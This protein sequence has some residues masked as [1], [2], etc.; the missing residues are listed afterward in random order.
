ML[1]NFLIA[2]AALASTVAGAPTVEKQRR[3]PTNVPSYVLDYGEEISE[4]HSLHP[5]PPYVKENFSRMLAKVWSNELS[6]HSS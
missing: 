4:P 2:V 5:N 3:A 6:Y 1:S